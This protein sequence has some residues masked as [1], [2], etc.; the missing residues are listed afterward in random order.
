VSDRVPCEAHDIRVQELVTE[1]RH[2]ILE[3]A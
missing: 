3:P 2:R 1:A